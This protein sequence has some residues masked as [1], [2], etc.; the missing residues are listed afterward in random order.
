MAGLRSSISRFGDVAVNRERVRRI[1]GPLFEVVRTP[2]PSDA[3]RRPEVL[4]QG[5][6]VPAPV[7]ITALG[8]L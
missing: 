2:Q 4:A 7:L 5:P 8:G 3:S 6:I 1:G